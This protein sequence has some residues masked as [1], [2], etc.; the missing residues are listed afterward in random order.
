MSE[1]DD[2]QSTVQSPQSAGTIPEKHT[3]GEKL[4]FAPLFRF[5]DGCHTQSIV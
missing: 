2:R 3:L 4:F 1:S 5:C